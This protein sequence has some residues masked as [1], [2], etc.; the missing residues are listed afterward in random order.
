LRLCLARC[1]VLWCRRASAGRAACRR[2]NI[3]Q[4]GQ[5]WQTHST[6]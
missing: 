5:A 1:G 4:R 3:P 2:Y 6:R